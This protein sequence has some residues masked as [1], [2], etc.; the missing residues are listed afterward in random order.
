MS[1]QLTVFSEIEKIAAEQKL[2]ELPAAK[3]DAIEVAHGDGLAGS[4]FNY[5]FGAHT[6][7]EWI[8]AVAGELKH[9]KLATLLLPG[10]GTIHDLRHAYDL[11]VRSVR[12][13]THSTEADI[14]KQHI[15]YARKL[16]MDVAGFLMMSHM[17][18]PE[19]L[20][21]QAKL[22]ESYGAH[23]VYVTDSGG[24]LLTEE[25]AARLTEYREVEECH[26]IAGEDCILAKVR[27]TDAAALNR[28]LLEMKKL[29][30]VQRT[31]TTIVLS[32]HFERGI[33]P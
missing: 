27:T 2:G 32:T 26:S 1:I 3:V 14:S 22:M 15:E 31:L 17:N 16:G 29:P 18:S 4:S 21:Q 24:R 12:V 8:E 5:G 11:G 25:V 9:A 30:G 13:A 19:G 10:I 28:L 33:Q 7:W 23:C 20:A 6:D